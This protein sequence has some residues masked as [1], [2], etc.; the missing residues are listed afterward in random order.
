MTPRSGPRQVFETLYCAVGRLSDRYIL[1][2]HLLDRH[3]DPAASGLEFR[4]TF[5]ARHGQG[6]WV[7]PLVV[8]SLSL[9]V[10]VLNLTLIL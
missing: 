4:L 6:G 8:V 1:R 7:L 3:T 9:A 2:N 10:P 5:G